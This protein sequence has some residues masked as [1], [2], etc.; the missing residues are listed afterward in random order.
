MGHRAEHAR[1]SFPSA[2]RTLSLLL[3]AQLADDVAR[4]VMFLHALLRAGEVAHRNAGLMHRLRVAGDERMPPGKPAAF[5]HAPVAAGRGKPGQRA[6][7]FRRQVDAVGHL[8]EAVFVVRAAAL[9]DV[10]ERAGKPR[11]DDLA[12]VLVL[13]LVQ[14]AAAAAVTEPLPL[15]G[16]H[17]FQRLRF[18]VGS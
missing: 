9:A 5:L 15:F 18:P 16:G 11:Q 7:L 8:R 1:T 4:P 6:H 3:F 17:V 14:A 12:R 10:E 13:Q 2:R